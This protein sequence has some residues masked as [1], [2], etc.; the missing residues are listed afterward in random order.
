M[1]LSK[2]TSC[3]VC[4]G[5]KMVVT[6]IW[7]TDAFQHFFQPTEAKLIEFAPK[8]ATEVGGHEQ[9]I[10]AWCGDCGIMYHPVSV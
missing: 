6:G 3:R 5:P 1:T 7:N 4:N 10:R 2:S 8:P 9:V